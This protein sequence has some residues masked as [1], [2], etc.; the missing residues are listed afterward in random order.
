M[1]K[2]FKCWSCQSIFDVEYKKPHKGEKK[3]Y[4][5][6]VEVFTQD[7]KVYDKDNHEVIVEATSEPITTCSGDYNVRV[8]TTCP[9]CGS[10]NFNR[11]LDNLK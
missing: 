3:V 10:N 8:S 6:D 5:C 9:T 1:Y 11:Y 2:G 7:G 4:T